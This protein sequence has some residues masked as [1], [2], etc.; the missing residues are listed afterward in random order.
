M[1]ITQANT[2]GLK[3]TLNIVI[4]ANE[5]SDR[6]TE[7]LGEF[8]ERVQFKGFRKG[9]VP[10]AHLKKLYGR[11]LMAE[12]LDQAVRD[13]SSQAI[14]DR[15]ERPAQQPDI[16]LPDDQAEI[17][18][19]IDGKADLAYSMTFEVLPEIAIA[20][21][22]KLKLERLTADVDDAA[23]DKALGELADRSVSYTRR[24]R[25]RGWRR[26][27]RHHRLRRQDRRRGIRRRHG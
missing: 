21:L 17:E 1:E 7:R 26:R 6:F 8:R 2:D 13:T 3:R 16:K 12:V 18:R 24:G 4:G 9:K 11:S 15:K 5:L 20:D 19:V 23:I 22:S 27:P 10:V 25:P 14:A